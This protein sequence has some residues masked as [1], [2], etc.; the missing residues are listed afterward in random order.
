[1]RHLAEW[2]IRTILYIEPEITNYLDDFLFIAITIWICNRMVRI[3]L[4]LCEQ[5][6]CP[7]S[8]EKTEWATQLI[9]FLGILMNGKLL[10]LLVPEE[11]RFKAIN[12][13]QEV[14][15]KKKVTIKEI[16]KLTGTLNFLNRA[17]VIKVKDVHNWKNK[18]KVMFIPH[19]S[20]MHGEWDKP[21]I[22][23]LA[24]IDPQTE[25]KK[26]AQ[27]ICPFK[28]LR[29]YLSVRGSF[30]KPQEQFFVFNDHSPVTQVQ[31]C[32]LIKA[33]I[34][35]NN[36][37]DRLYTVHGIR[38]GRSCDL[39]DMGVSVETIKKLGRWKSSA[40]FSYLCNQ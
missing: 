27:G 10:K 17:I 18:N 23:K 2:K 15:Q 4:D 16:Q 30:A 34:R 3:F 36:L 35:F 37:D 12:L 31:F 26:E 20:K 22:I 6:N 19:S 32:N 13:I 24:E 9:V 29:E 8:D 25:L 21:Q 33:L 11:K 1:M 40:V 7:I 38:A 14:M 5:V 39:F 28:I